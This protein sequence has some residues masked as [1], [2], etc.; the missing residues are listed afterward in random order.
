MQEDINYYISTLT[1]YPQLVKLG[2]LKAFAL[3]AGSLV[4]LHWKPA[5][6]CAWLL[7]LRW[8]S[9]LLGIVCG[10]IFCKAPIVD[11]YCTQMR[12]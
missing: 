7:D 6:N 1:Q 5:S 9:C 3:L 8:R 12:Q 4:V 10:E 2:V 11:L